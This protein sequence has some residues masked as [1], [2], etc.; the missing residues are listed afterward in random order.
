MREINEFGSCLGGSSASIE[1]M[2]R[3]R[4]LNVNSLLGDHVRHCDYAAHETIAMEGDRAEFLFEVIDGAVMLYKLLQDG[5]RQVVELLA[6]GDV[7]GF[8]DGI[9]H[10]CSAESLVS[11]RLAVIPSN[12]ADRDPDLQLRLARRCI[13][14]MRTLHNHAVLLGRKSAMERVASIKS[15]REFV[16]GITS[17]IKHQEVAGMFTNTTSMLGTR[18]S[19]S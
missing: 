13:F 3:A 7:F 10:D 2:S 11:T 19:T 5:R 12:A 1:S 15:F 16:I 17:H 6:P 9:N 8:G 18:C 4:A 14:Q